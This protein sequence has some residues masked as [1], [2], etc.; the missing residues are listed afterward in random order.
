M[1]NFA[2]QK[3]KKSQ[4]TSASE[5]NETILVYAEVDSGYG[6]T[7]YNIYCLSTFR[8][9]LQF[10]IKVL[11]ISVFDSIDGK[12][13]QLLYNLH[14]HYCVVTREMSDFQNLNFQ[15]LK[16][17]LLPIINRI[18]TIYKKKLANSQFTNSLSLIPKLA[19][20]F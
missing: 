3:K 2:L 8:P 6:Q 1:L 17:Q 12:H 10:F 18:F 11:N 5:N 9:T 7:Q 13:D 4:L 20:I 15:E 14:K 16:S 19:Y